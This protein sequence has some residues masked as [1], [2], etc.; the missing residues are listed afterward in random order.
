MEKT[1]VGL[2][3]KVKINGKEVKA[4]I[5]TG[6]HHNSI[7]KELF[8]KLNLG[9]VIGKVSI[10]SATGKQERP[11]VNAELEIKGRKLKTKFNIANRKHLTYPVLIGLDV[12][13]Q[14][15]LVDASK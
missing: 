3:E 1:V 4:K 11:V 7:C 6:A 5:D 9:P 13:K 14:G 8:E 10:K 12:L 15:F 2:V